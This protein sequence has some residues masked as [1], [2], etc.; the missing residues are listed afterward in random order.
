MSKA[1]FWLRCVAVACMVGSIYGCGDA[2]SGAPQG[3]S[4][5]FDPS[6]ASVYPVDPASGCFMSTPKAFRIKI[7]DAAG[8]FVN[9]IAITIDANASVTTLYDDVDN[10]GTLEGAELTP[11]TTSTFMTTTGSFGTKIVFASF[12]IG[13]TACLMPAGLN[14]TTTLNAYSGAVSGQATIAAKG[15]P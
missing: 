11:L 1:I 14:Y 4:I 12:D 3:S 5:S 6:S 9:D 15:A 2:Q 8:N 10:S 7:T 13:G